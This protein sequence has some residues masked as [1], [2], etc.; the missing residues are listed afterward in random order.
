MT[1]IRSITKN[2]KLECQLLL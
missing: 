1:K 2:F